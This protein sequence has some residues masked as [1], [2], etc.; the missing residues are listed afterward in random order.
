MNAT[1]GHAPN[2]PPPLPTAEDHRVRAEVAHALHATGRF[3]VKCVTIHV[4]NG[5]VRLQ[6]RVASYYHKQVAQA[7]AGTVLG[8]CRLVN[9]IVVD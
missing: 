7:A 3:A 1:T 8:D 4:S 9:E 5:V 6:G 2:S